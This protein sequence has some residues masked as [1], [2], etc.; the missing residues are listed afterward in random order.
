V[1]ICVTDDDNFDWRGFAEKHIGG[2]FYKNEAKIDI[3]DQ[4]MYNWDEFVTYCW[5]YCH[6]YQR[7][8]KTE[9]K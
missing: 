5:E 1:R 8:K 2:W 3:F 7:T 6:K 9:E 4:L